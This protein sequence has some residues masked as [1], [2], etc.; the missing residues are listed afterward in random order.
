MNLSAQNAL[1][2]FHV[3][4]SV[5]QSLK[6]IIAFAL[7]L[8]VIGVAWQ[9]LAVFAK[10]ASLSERITLLA[11]REIQNHINFIEEEIKVSEKNSRMI[12]LKNWLNS[13]KAVA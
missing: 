3:A 4:S 2:W 11:K 10:D 6:G 5:Y 7:A 8:K 13:L 9:T 1:N 12:E